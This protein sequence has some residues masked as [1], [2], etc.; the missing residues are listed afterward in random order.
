VGPDRLKEM[1]RTN[2]R[3]VRRGLGVVSFGRDGRK[4]DAE[5]VDKVGDIVPYGR[6]NAL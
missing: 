1:A 4:M 3:D 6:R 5:E 2:D